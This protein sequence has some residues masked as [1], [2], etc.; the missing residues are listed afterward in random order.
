MNVTC[1]PSI[2]QGIAKEL[3]ERCATVRAADVQR[4]DQHNIA[5]EL[6]Y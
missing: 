5:Y 2:E 1:E 4:T 6:V 3:G